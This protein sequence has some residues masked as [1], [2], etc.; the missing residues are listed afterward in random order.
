MSDG[1]LVHYL[2]DGN[3]TKKMR[4]PL[5]SS[6]EDALERACALKLHHDVQFIQGP[7][8]EIIDAKTIAD[9][10]AAR[11]RTTRP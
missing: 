6:K 9:W 11:A 1:W 10:C 2:F 5:L 4:T 3:A 7:N 8:A